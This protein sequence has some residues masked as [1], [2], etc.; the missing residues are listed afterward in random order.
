MTE[1]DR[2]QI[3]G[4]L[5]GRFLVAMP[6]MGDERF[7]R[8]V[9]LI[10]AHDRHHAM[11]IT[12]NRALEGLSLS[13]VLSGLDVPDADRV[14]NFPLVQGGP[15]GPERGFVLHS[16]DLDLPGATLEVDD[17]IRMTA[18]LEALNAMTSQSPPR[19]AVLALG[20]AGWGAGQLEEELTQNAW[21]VTDA[22]PAIVF[23]P[24][25]SRKWERALETLGIAP[26]QLHGDIG[27]A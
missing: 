25:H 27:R 19:Q 9:V 3:E 24:D 18:T 6:S 26:H 10:C 22:S 2:R 23:D 4:F 20:F 5:R 13:E 8:A 12:V 1:A 16:P 7:S 21:M 14:P 15:V 11:G 17:G